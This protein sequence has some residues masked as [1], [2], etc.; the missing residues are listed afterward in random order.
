MSL[1]PPRLEQTLEFQFGRPLSFLHA[2]GVRQASSTVM[3]MGASASGGMLS[4]PGGVLSFAVFF[5]PTGFSR[6]FGVPMVELSHRAHDAFAVLGVGLSALQARLGECDT[7]IQRVLTVEAFLLKR[8]ARFAP[9]RS[10]DDPAAAIF[11]EYGAVCIR[12]VAHVQGLGLRQFE[13]KFLA[14]TGLQPKRYARIARFQ[15][16]LDAKISW[17]TRP[18]LDIAHGLGYHDEMHLV[19]DFH[20]LAGMTPGKSLSLVGDTR[21]PAVLAP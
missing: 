20:R 4:L 17:P 11:A 15:S 13:R 14:Q 6:L 3:I 10:M 7:F 8:A 16:A 19:R 5:Q 18:W 12:D 21:P 2:N 1:V 9:S